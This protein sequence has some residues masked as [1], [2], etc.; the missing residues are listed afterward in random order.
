MP[1]FREASWK[2]AGFDVSP[3]VIGRPPRP[4]ISWASLN[5]SVLPVPASVLTTQ[6][7]GTPCRV[8]TCVSEGGEVGREGGCEG[9]REGA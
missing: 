8:A 6:S 7:D 3:P 2:I 1:E 4:S 9:G 5:D